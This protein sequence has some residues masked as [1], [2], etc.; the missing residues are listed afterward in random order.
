M[1]GTKDALKLIKN[2]MSVGIF[3]GPEGGFEENEVEKTVSIGAKII[4]LGQ[5]I[6]RTETA[7]ITS[8][9]MCMLH[10]EM[11]TGGDEK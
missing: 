1:K 10:I 2:G 4:S 6:L 8:V 5:R 3:I 11:N 9:A 7:A